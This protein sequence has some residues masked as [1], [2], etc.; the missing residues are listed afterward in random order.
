MKTVLNDPD[1]IVLI[2]LAAVMD[3]GLA[4]QCPMSELTVVQ[5]DTTKIQKPGNVQLDM[6]IEDG[7]MVRVILDA[8]FADL[9]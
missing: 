1:R 8:H 9:H 3:I 2:A 4:C 7:A 6:L 5:T